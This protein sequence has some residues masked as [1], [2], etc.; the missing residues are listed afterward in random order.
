M[1]ELFQYG[2]GV[3]HAG[4][5]RT[6]RNLTEKMFESGAIK[7][8]CCTAT[9]AWG[10]NLPAAVV[11]VKGTQVYDS[12][13]GGFVDLGISDVIQ[14][15]GRAGRPQYEKFG[16]GIL[17]TTS[18]R[19]DHYVSLLTQQHPIESKFG[20]KLIDNLNAEISLGTVTNVHEAV[21]WLGYTYMMV[22]MKQNPLGY[23]IDWRELQ[24]DPT[25]TNK[26][27][28][29][30]ITHA[31]RLHHLQMIILMKTPKHSQQRI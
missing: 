12:K 9:L 26:R 8:L 17:C 10:V 6:D 25:L 5:L 19:L 29:L 28:E 2:F 27:R 13:A 31:R 15:F 7:V 30:V 18:D 23:G 21:Q 11:I 1:K 20:E 24:E 3:H 14:I 16:T 4:M 22:R